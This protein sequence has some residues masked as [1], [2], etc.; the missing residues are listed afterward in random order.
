MADFYQTG[1]V[2]TLHRLGDH[3]VETLEQ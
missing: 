3:K 2:A 1:A